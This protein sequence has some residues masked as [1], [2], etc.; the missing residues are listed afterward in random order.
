M[1]QKKLII[2]TGVSGDLGKAYYDHYS[3]DSSVKCI[4]ITRQDFDTRYNWRKADLTDKLQ[5]MTAIKSIP[6]EGIEEIVLIHPV[7][8]F[9]FEDENHAIIDHN[10]DGIDDEVY[11]SNIKTFQNTIEPL[12]ERLGDRKLTICQFGSISDKYGVPYWNSYTQSK[13]KLRTIVK[14]LSSQDNT[15]GIFFDLSSVDTGNENKTRPC[16]D[17]TYWI[18]PKEVVEQSLQYI[19]NTEK[20][21]E[22][23]LYRESPHYHEKWFTDKDAIHNRWIREMG[24][25]EE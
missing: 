17:K 3:N 14:E 23:S 1:N 21:Q 10:K 22:I 6:L 5:T 16:A 19:N 4:G 25:S 9:K 15:R 11:D 20:F 8:K 12:Y 18:T 7:G 13:N 2:I 24:K